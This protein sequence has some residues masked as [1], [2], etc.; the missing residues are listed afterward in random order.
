MKRRVVYSENG[1]KRIS[2]LGYLSKE[3]FLEF[4]KYCGTDVIFI[5]W[6][7]EECTQD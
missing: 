2:K 3:D 6:E 4:T 5:G 1:I 7:A